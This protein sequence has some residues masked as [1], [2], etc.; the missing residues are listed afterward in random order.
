MHDNKAYIPVLITIPPHR[1]L[2]VFSAKTEVELVT[3][4]ALL[5]S[6]NSLARHHCS[7][8]VDVVLRA[9]IVPICVNGVLSGAAVCQWCWH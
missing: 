5:S 8:D 7:Q 4:D 1:V 3:E 2:L 9:V 6:H